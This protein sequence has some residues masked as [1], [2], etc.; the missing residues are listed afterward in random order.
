MRSSLLLAAASAPA[1]LAIFRDRP[2]NF[3]FVI[4]DGMAPV[5]QTIARTFLE[6]QADGIAIDQMPIGNTRTHSANNFV[7]DSA[8]AGTALASGFKTNNG[9][10]GVLPDGQPVGTILEA[11]KLEGY[12]TGLVVT[13]VIN[14]ATPA[15]FSS[16]SVSRNALPA[17]AA[18]QIGYSHPLNQSVDILLGGGTCYFQPRSAPT[19]CRE[20]DTDLFAFA[21]S[22][23]YT[24]LTNRSAFDALSSSR[25]RT[26]LPWL[27]TFS[28]GDLAYDLDRQS[29]PENVREPSLSEMTSQALSALD[30]GVRCRG[31]RCRV[32]R[33]KGYF[34]MIEASRID[35]ASHASDGAAHLHEVLEYNRVMQL[36]KEW[37]DE[38]PDTAM[39]SV[40]DHETGGLTVPSRYDVSKLGG[41][42]KTAETLGE[43]WERYNGTD[44]RG[45]LT[46]TVLPAYGVGDAS[47]AEVERLLGSGE[48]FALELANV[49][50]ARSG[51]K[52]ST[53]GHTGVDTTLF[54]YAKGRMG[55][56]LKVALAGN[57]DNIEIPRYLERA[58][59]VSLDKV[60]RELR[61][62]GTAWIP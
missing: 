24:V 5:S 33:G 37:I 15:A 45:F 22:Q 20:D 56:E 52:W 26:P 47:G 10:L 29:Q 28:P 1:A 17:I 7:T 12:L 18:Q 48:D 51:L 14:H 46:G 55:E 6:A 4:P 21:Q 49:L 57:H 36:V 54:G 27:G 35:H 60:T 42:K 16:H 13:S 62:K 43:E 30:A 23:G 31:P 59:D 44:R 19:S 3:I 50:N 53:G 38:H 34:L 61:A 40:A 9:A 11:A 8:A 25:G 58:L 41:A 39:I 2:R 32:Q